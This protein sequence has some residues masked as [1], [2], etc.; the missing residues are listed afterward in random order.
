MW[1]RGGRGEG[2]IH[3]ENWREAADWWVGAY[4]GRRMVTTRTAE[5]PDR[6]RQLRLTA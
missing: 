2:E 1:G 4:T 6:E 5:G 3:D